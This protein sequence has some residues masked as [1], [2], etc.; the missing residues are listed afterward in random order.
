MRRNLFKDQRLNLIALVVGLASAALGIALLELIHL[1]TNVTFHGDFSVAER[2]ADFS[3]WG[4]WAVFVPAAGGLVIGLIARFGSPAIQGHGIP[5]AMQGVILNRS[6][7]PLKVAILKPLSTA[8]SIGTGGPF[9]AEGPVIATGG[10]VGSLFGQWLPVNDIERKIL[11]SAGAAAGMTAVFGTPL[12]GVLLAVELLLFEFRWRSLMPVALAVG[13][14]MALRGTMDEPFPMLP[15][16]SPDAP[17]PL[18]AIGAVLVGIAGGV[19]SVG[20]THALHWIEGIF[21]KIPLPWMWFPMIG[22]LVVG[23]L[24]WIDPRVLGAG[25]FNL[26]ELLAGEMLFTALITLLVF[27]FLAWSICLGSGTAGGTLAP[28]MTM[29]GCV[30]AIVC[31]GLHQVPGFDVFPMGI[32]AL[33]GMAAVFAGCSRAFLT[34][35]A[36]SFEATHSSAAFG[37][38]LLGC[39]FA[40]LVS[41]MLMKESIMTEKL[42]RKGVRVPSD[43]EPDTLASRTV[44]SAMI[45]NPL[46]VPAEMSVRELVEKITGAENPWNRARLFPVLENGILRAVV[47]RADILAVPTESLD[48]QVIEIGTRDVYTVCPGDSLAEASEKMISHRIGRL[49]V[50]SPDGKGTLLGLLTRREILCARSR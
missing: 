20:M 12:A 29:G 37:P 16:V 17:G 26:R 35:V 19:F 36:F 13:A 6:K 44:E 49:P 3:T 7:I 15:L 41:R 32:A 9:G 38:L 22:G 21:E 2:R 40:V 25:Y 30:G 10:A 23:L 1:I 27:K 47:S 34:S 31:L 43:Y 48:A 33:V 11:L 50:V 5:E 8:L 42:S 46:I 4:A 14:A 45:T 24:A 28:V 39:A 18:I